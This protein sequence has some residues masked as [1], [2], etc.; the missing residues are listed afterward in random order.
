MPTDVPKQLVNRSSINFTG[1]AGMKVTCQLPDGS[2]KD[3]D[4]LTTHK[5]YNFAHGQVYR[6]RLSN[7][8]PDHPGK[9]FYPTLEVAPA[10]PRTDTFL[11]HSSVP[12]NFSADD[13]A[14]VKAGNLVVKVIYLP[15]PSN[16]DFSTIIGPEE[17]VSVRLE[18]GADPVAEAQRRGTILAIIRLGNVD[19]ENRAAPALAPRPRER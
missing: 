4:A 6:L 1:P 5:E 12:V 17:V 2:F 7:I 10:T 14:Q 9:S 18:P 11:K 15:N 8:L 3:K 13:F 19:L 16:Q